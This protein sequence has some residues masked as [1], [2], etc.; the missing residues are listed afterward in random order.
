MVYLLNK[1]LLIVMDEETNKT[2]K[3]KNLPSSLV[4]INSLISLTIQIL[5]QFKLRA[6]MTKMIHT[7]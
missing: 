3:K 1:K 2:N 7:K 4:L 5:K 6:A